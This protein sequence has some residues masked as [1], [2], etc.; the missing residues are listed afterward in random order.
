MSLGSIYLRFR[1]KYGHGLK[2]AYYRDRVRPRIL[3]T[4]PVLHTNSDE[5]EIH[6]L[7]WREDWLNVI[8]MLKTFYHYSKRNYSLCIHEDGTLEERELSLLEYHFPNARIVRRSDADS[9]VK[10]ALA[11]LPQSRKFR[12]S[13]PLALKVFDFRIYLNNERML[14]LD[15]D[16]LFFSE[17]VE[18]LKRIEDVSYDKNSLNQDWGNGY[19][20]IIDEVRDLVPFTICERINSGLGLIHRKSVDFAAIEEFMALPNILSHNHRVEQTLI[21]LYSCRYGFEFLPKEYDVHLGPFIPDHPCRHFTGP[22]RQ[23]M[24]SEGIHYL[25]QKGFITCQSHE[26]APHY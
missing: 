2:V 12:N 4:P 15:S 20:I 10:K 11:H 7:T 17:P 22:I 3:Q 8:W 24:Y 25:V 6:V 5:C 21:A 26:V 18:L 23:R 9:E 14:I 16:I 13:N 1:Q 19:S